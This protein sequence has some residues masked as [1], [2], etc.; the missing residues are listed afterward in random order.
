MKR[1]LV[2]IGLFV[3]AGIGLWLATGGI[4]RTARDRIGAALVAEGLPQPMAS[5]MGERLA[6]RLSLAQMRRI[7]QAMAG[8]ADEGQGSSGGV[9]VMLE[10]IR[11]I[12][13]PE[14]LD[15]AAGTAAICAFGGA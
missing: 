5:C 6:E 8:G 14:I 10:R 15:I 13:D 9:L 3:A 1:A 11:R 12:D 4:Q 2:V 7:E